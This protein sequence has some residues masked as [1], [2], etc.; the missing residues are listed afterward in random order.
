MRFC[1]SASSSWAS[2]RARSMD[3]KRF[4]SA[5]SASSRDWSFASSVACCRAW[6]FSATSTSRPTSFS[7]WSYASRRSM[8][9]SRSSATSASS[10]S[11]YLG[12]SG[13]G[14]L[15]C[16]ACACRNAS[17]R[18]GDPSAAEASAPRLPR[19]SA[20][21]PE[22]RRDLMSS[23]IL[24]RSVSHL[25]CSSVNF[26]S[27]TWSNP[28]RSSRS[29][30]AVSSCAASLSRSRLRPSAAASTSASRPR[31]A[32]AASSMVTIISL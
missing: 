8:R 16:V 15:R 18:R 4:C 12:S 25:A 10:S 32:C 23:C 17:R 7:S 13:C 29:I 5:L 3:L 9:R 6:R 31:Q 28:A 21:A 1:A 26:S 11:T 22:D 24:A 30:L 2:L 14:A 20:T 19:A 27:K